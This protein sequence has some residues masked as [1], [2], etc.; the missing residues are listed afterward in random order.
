MMP[1]IF[2]IDKPIGISSFGVIREL[3]KI[4]RDNKYQVPK[5]GYAGTLDPL[6]SGL[7]LVGLDK[8]TKKLTMLTQCDKEYVTE[9]CLGIGTTTQDREGNVVNTKSVKVPFAF[10]YIQQTL[11]EMEGELC[12]P[13]SGFSAIK[14]DGIP[15]YR[16]ARQAIATGEEVPMIA[17]RQ[18]YVYEA[19]LLNVS[20]EIRSE[21]L[22]QI[23]SVRFLVKKGTYIRSLAQSLGERLGAYPAHLHSLRRTKVGSYS[24]KDAYS[25]EQIEKKLK[26][27]N[28][29]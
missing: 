14:K 21:I 1:D 19:E 12:L 28:L 10:D 29:V 23:I 22:V 13:V 20:A 2:L 16:R 24:V 26:E 9:I 15:M 27:N 11:S 5:M 4:F 7:M 17:Q 18:M 8:G 3:R 25:L 6:A